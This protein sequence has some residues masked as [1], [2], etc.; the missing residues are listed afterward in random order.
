MEYGGLSPEVERVLAAYAAYFG[1]K[2]AHRNVLEVACGTGFWTRKLAL[3]ARSVV[4]T[5]AAPEMLA[6]AGA[7]QY[8]LSNVELVLDD[9][10]SLSKVGAGFDGG[11]HFQWISHVPRA[12]LHEFFTRF[13]GRL[14]AEAV[15]VFGDNK[16]QGTQPDS[17]GNLYQDR[18]LPDGSRHRVIKNWLTR[19][20]LR[21]LLEPWTESLELQ[22]FERDWFVCYRL[23]P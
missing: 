3:Q 8:E 19:D 14:S 5:D 4:A 20:E 21:T 12:R 10:Y 17:D 1:D 13:H 2:L 7:R 11:F 15:V 23:R 6:I 22:E 16:E 9:A 18:S